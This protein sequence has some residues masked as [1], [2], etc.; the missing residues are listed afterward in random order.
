MVH[1]TSN[2]ETEAG[3]SLGI[4]DKQPSLISEPQVNEFQLFQKMGG[5]H[6]RNNPHR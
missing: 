1:N 4:T 6:L 5:W 3:G 2:K